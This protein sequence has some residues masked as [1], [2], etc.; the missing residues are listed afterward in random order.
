MVPQTFLDKTELLVMSPRVLPLIGIMRDAPR[1]LRVDLA[2]CTF[3]CFL[4]SGWAEAP[5][6]GHEETQC[7]AW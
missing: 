6:Q 5:F 1:Q 2:C 7:Q 4:Y 3:A